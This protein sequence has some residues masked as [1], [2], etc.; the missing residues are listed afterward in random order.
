MI[1]KKDVHRSRFD[2]LVMILSYTKR[3]LQNEYKYSYQPL[4][5]TKMNLLD[6]YHLMNEGV[7]WIANNVIP[8]VES[9][10]FN[11][12]SG[13]L[14]TKCFTFDIQ[15]EISCYIE[16][17]QSYALYFS[18]NENKELFEGCVH[19]YQWF[20]SLHLF[21]MYDIIGKYDNYQMTLNMLMDRLIE[22][23]QN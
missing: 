11:N 7:T 9:Q 1:D 5:K 22:M 17:L 19:R 12:L 10:Q 21:M 2:S 15:K 4:L 3:Y 14:E 23:K 6:P 20:M 13:L 18:E 16:M 8:K